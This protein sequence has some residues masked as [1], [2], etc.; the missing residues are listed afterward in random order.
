MSRE[1]GISAAADAALREILQPTGVGLQPDSGSALVDALVL[2]A[3]AAGTQVAP[4]RIAQ[5]ARH[6]SDEVDVCAQRLGIPLRQVELAPDWWRAE[7]G[8]Y[9]VADAGDGQPAAALPDGDGYVLVLAHRTLRVGADLAAKVSARAWSVTPRLP[10]HP[11]DLRALARV[12]TT[13]SLRR[14]LARLVAYAILI[15]LLGLAFPL[16][17]GW[18]IGE[19]VPLGSV[20]RTVAAGA[21][22]LLVALAIANVTYLQAVVIQRVAAR[23]DA[24]AVVVVIDRL[25]RLPLPFFREHQAGSLVQRVQGLDQAAPLLS[26]AFL[27][28][29]SGA[30]LAVSGIVVM[31]VLYLHL[32]LVVLAVVAVVGGAVWFILHRQLQAQSTYYERNIALSGLTLAMFSGI[33]KIRVGA[34]EGRVRS[35][36][37]LRYAEQQ[38]AAAAVANWLQRLSFAAVALP[39]AV[40]LTVVVGSVQAGGASQ[41][42]RFTS[43]LTASGQVSTACA[44]MLVPLSALAASVPVIRAMRTVLRATP[45]AAGFSAEPARLEGAVELTDVSFSYGDSAILRNVDFRAG[46]GEFVALVGPSGSGKTTL[47]RLLLGLEQPRAG[48]V[49]YDG[50][51]LDRLGAEAVRREIGVVTQSAQLSTGSILENIVGASTLTE[52]DAWQAAELAGIADD[53]RAMPM[54]L[55]TPVSDGA[56]TF[57][58]GQKQRI[59]LARALAR[60]PRVLILDEA[61]SALDE[62]TQAAVAD[63]LERLGVTRIVVAHRL[64]T[65]RGADRIYVLDRGQ[66][67]QAGSFDKLVGAPGLFRDLVARQLPG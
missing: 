67:V 44:S 54:G 40:T 57:S 32:A 5:V 39:V 37:V 58:G 59:L 7:T 42:G 33:S 31:C 3:A 66:V 9:V 55:R 19:L 45:E 38:Q 43:F 28:L 41:L 22:L 1:R 2:A 23:V 53:I 10:G 20:S 51:P 27:R 29:L 24:R 12:V 4:E 11:A 60:K 46:P 34:A 64:S 18:V 17:S 14:D 50:R 48:E 25:L 35:L 8:P 26:L 36:W 16:W 49:M 47:T 63:S 52:D 65:I 61:T 30:V 6:P 56:A 15:A 21:L 13:G 62:P